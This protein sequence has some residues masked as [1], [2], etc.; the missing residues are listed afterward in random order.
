MDIRREGKELAFKIGTYSED[1]KHT[2]SQ[3]YI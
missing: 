1:N 2:K 3:K